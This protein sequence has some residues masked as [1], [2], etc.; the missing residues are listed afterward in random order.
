VQKIDQL[1][2][3]A[4]KPDYFIAVAIPAKPCSMTPVLQEGLSRSL[5]T[6]KN[7]L[8]LYVFLVGDYFFDSTLNAALMSANTAVELLLEYLGEES[9]EVTPAIKQLESKETGV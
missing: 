6:F 3:M 4:T 9:A 7:I 8:E 1:L 5:S 2:T